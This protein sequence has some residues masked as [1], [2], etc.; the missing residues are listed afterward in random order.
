MSKPFNKLGF[1]LIEVIIVVSVTLILSTFAIGYN[2]EASRQLTLVTYQS[3]LVNLISTAKSFSVHT[4]IEGPIVVGAPKVCGYGVSLGKDING[5][6]NGE[7]FIFRDLAL[8]CLLTD[9]KYGPGD[10]KLTGDKNVLRIDQSTSQF[11]VSETT[12]TDIIFIPPDPAIIINGNPSTTE[13]VITL[14]L[15]SG[16]RKVMVKIN[17]SGSIST[18]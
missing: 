2:R 8:N 7:A 18:K 16:A 9:N 17:D 15:K 10:K 6:F 11:I 12:F 14:G 4:F 13:A 3:K 5:V 1:T